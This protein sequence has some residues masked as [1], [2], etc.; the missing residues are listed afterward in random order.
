MEV[1][2]NCDRLRNLRHSS[3]LPL[4]FTEQGVAMLVR[5]DLLRKDIN[6]LDKKIDQVFRFL[7]GKID[8]MNGN[9]AKKIRKRIGYKDYEK[10]EGQ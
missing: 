7:L 3:V 10:E 9:N 4:V 1:V 8:A 2:T 5:D 6:A